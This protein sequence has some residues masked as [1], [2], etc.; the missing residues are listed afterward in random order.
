MKHIYKAGLLLLILVGGFVHGQSHFAAKFSAGQET[1]VSTATATGTAS[2]VLTDAGLRF[3]ITLEG[4]S[5]AINAAHFHNAPMGTDGPVV[6]TITGDFSGTTATGLWTAGDG[7]PLTAGLIAELLAGHLYLNVHTSTNPAGEIRAQV[8]PS[9]GV[10]GPVV[11]T[12]LNDF[13]EIPL[14]AHGPPPILNR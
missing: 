10:N 13:T 11:R 1:H 8:L 3:Y 12:I 5:G 2:C 6:R 7:E 14:P 9:A 4:L